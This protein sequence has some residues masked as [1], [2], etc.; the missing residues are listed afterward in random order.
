[1]A[2][3]AR[4]RQIFVLKRALF[5]SSSSTVAVVKSRSLGKLILAE[6]ILTNVAFLLLQNMFWSQVPKK[7]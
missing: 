1:M 4:V 3:L 5:R 6:P 7:L 2:K